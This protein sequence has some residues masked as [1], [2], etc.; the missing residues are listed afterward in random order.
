MHIKNTTTWFTRFSLY[1]ENK[2]YNM[3]KIYEKIREY[4]YYFLYFLQSML[5]TFFLIGFLSIYSNWYYK[6]RP[7]LIEDSVTHSMCHTKSMNTDVVDT[8]L[9]KLINCEYGYS[10]PMSKIFQS[11]SAF[12]L[13]F[14]I[15]DEKLEY[16]TAVCNFI[17]DKVN[18]SLTNKNVND[19]V[20]LLDQPKDYCTGIAAL[21]KKAKSLQSVISANSLDKELTFEYLKQN[22]VSSIS[23]DNYQDLYLHNSNLFQNL[24]KSYKKLS[25]IIKQK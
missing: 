25:F 15:Q 3:F 24:I 7:T 18:T 19:A 5:I 17:I 12:L 8:Y 11:Q 13:L 1:C 9:S 21:Y 6:E 4:D 22:P 10:V 20:A 16:V 2:K 14:R 23:Q